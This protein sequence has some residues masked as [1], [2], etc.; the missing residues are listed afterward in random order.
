MKIKHLLFSTLAAVL[1]VAGFSSCSDDDDPLTTYVS[2]V[3]FKDADIEEGFIN[4]ELTWSKP[5]DQN[6]ITAIVLYK[7]EDGTVKGEKLAELS[8][9]AEK[10]VIPEGTEYFPYIILVSVLTTGQEDVYPVKIKMVDRTINS[11]ELEGVYILNQGKGGGN[12][13]NLAFFDYQSQKMVYNVF[14]DHNGKKMGDTGQDMIVYG[15]KMYV[16]AYGSNIIYVLDKSG[17]IKAEMQPVKDGVPQKP[18]GLT[19][20]AGNVYATLYD[21]H[22]A[23][24]DTAQMKIT[25]QVAVGRNPEF[26]R[27]ANGKLYVAN[28]GGLDY[29]TAL[30]YDKTVSVVDVAT[31]TETTKIPVVIN[32]DKLAVDSDGDIYVISNGDY[33]TVLN[34][35][36]R[37]NTKTDKATVVEGFNATWMAMNG[38]KLYYIYSQY[39]EFWNQ[40]ITYGVY[41]AKT[42]AIETTQFITDGTVIAK[43][44]SIS[45]D[46][47]YGYVYIG[48]SDFKTD[49]DMYVFSAEGKLITKFDTGG[50][51]P[52]LAFYVKK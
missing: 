35:V 11:P 49:G 39:D 38:D 16:A 41:N 15:S 10:Y 4:G 29:N 5:T 32:P 8:A 12:N 26:V 40:T 27:V 3:S 28:S 37:I 13:A 6:A 52:T 22:L 48:T 45:V 9:S 34:T 21:G 7:S 50:I 46:P 30:G 14:E 19:S 47:V 31:F 2:N 25:A 1:F 51:N 18:R 33:N 36:Q 24:I 44:Y 43:P 23:K 20:Y 42:E 17:T